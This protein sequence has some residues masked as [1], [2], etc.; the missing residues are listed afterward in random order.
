MCFEKYIIRS[1]QGTNWSSY[2]KPLYDSYEYISW[3]LT[4]FQ[5]H[6]EVVTG[7]ALKSAKLLPLVV[8]AKVCVIP[9]GSPPD[10]RIEGFSGGATK[11]SMRETPPDRWPLAPSGRV[12][13]K[14]TKYSASR[15]DNNEHSEYTYIYTGNWISLRHHWRLYKQ[16][17]AYLRGT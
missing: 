6:E 13:Q 15:I 5:K 2:P 1:T 9:V 14:S 17:Y 4:L 16:G 8:A 7:K 11:Y 10:Y 3:L 12:L